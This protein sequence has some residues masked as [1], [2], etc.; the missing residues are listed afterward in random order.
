MV[1]Q[2]Q[3]ENVEFS[4]FRSILKNNARSKSEINSKFTVANQH[5]TNRRVL[6]QQ[7]ELQFK[8]ETIKGLYLEQP[9]K[10]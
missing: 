5:P 6:H 9:F 2:K 8:E 3:P 4:D 7:I 10:K 1:D